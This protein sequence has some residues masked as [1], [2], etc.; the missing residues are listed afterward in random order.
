MTAEQAKAI[1]YLSGSALIFLL[2]YY[3]FLKDPKRP[4]NK[5]FFLLSISTVFWGISAGLLFLFFPKLLPLGLVEE[6]F[7]EEGAIKFTFLAF[8]SSSGSLFLASIFLH[9][10]LILAEKE[11]RKRTFFVYLPFLF[12]FFYGNLLYLILFILTKGRLP[13]LYERSDQ[14]ITT[15]F[16]FLFNIYL[17]V[18]FYFLF[19]KYFSLK[20]RQER[21]RFRYFLIGASIPAFP[22]S[23]LLFLF[24]FKILTAKGWIIFF[25]YFLGYLFVGIGILR[26]S[27]FIDYREILETIFEKLAEFVVILDREG[28]I[29]LANEST[30]SKLGY[31][32]EEIAEKKIDEISKEKIEEILKSLKEAEIFEKRTSFLTK[33]GKEIPTLLTGSLVRGAII[34]VGQDI[35]EL[36][37]YEKDLL[38]KVREKR[39]ELEEA[40]KVLEIKVA[41]RTRELREFAKSLEA[42]VERRTKELR[43]K[44]EELEKFHKLAVGRE[45][46]MV[47]LKREIE[48]LKRIR[49]T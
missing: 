21:K 44:L 3:V 31:S 13:K 41:A 49:K 39:E 24:L 18:A 10:S 15:F 22:G 1:L 37:K 9:L 19:K 12:Y 17:Y 48:K 34:L 26:H 2:G 7:K 8:L 14:I 43:E 23:V 16:Y 32:Q 42:E 6:I 47:E 29:I 28:F 5:I 27:L 40:K 30:L 35:S 36:V 46:K 25:L 38:E 33:E 4:Q 20:T 11:K 45:L